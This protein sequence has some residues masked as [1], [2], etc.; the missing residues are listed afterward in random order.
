RQAGAMIYIVL[1][2]VPIGLA[3]LLALLLAQ[4][5]DRPR[6]V[7]AWIVALLS[8]LWLGAILAGALIIAPPKAPIWVMTIGSA[9]VIWAGFVVP[10][11][12]TSLLMAGQRWGR[13]ARACLW[14]LLVMVA[15]AVVMR[16]VGLVPPPV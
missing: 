13:I 2:A 5:I 12:A 6:T 9:V 8:T 11:L 4:F 7:T 1:N 16:L 3:T 15:Q 10:A 14:W